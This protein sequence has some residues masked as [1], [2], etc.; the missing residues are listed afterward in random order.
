MALC[1]DLVHYGTLCTDLS[2]GAY[3]NLVSFWL[4]TFH[5]L[6]LAGWEG[7]VGSICKRL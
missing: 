1:Q 3:V 4:L 5:C 6:G 7:Q 2:K